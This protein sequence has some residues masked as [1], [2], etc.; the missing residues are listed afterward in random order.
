MEVLAGFL[1]NKWQKLG[2][3]VPPLVC[4]YI[5]YKVCCVVSRV[6][7]SGGRVMVKF[8]IFDF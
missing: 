2:E 3:N 8:Y 5:L 1:G 7:Q 6:S 4:S